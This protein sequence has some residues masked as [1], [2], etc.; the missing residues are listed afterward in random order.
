MTSL[1]MLQR[2]RTP[3]RFRL[4]DHRLN[5]LS[6]PVTWTVDFDRETDLILDVLAMSWRYP[7]PRFRREGTYERRAATKS[8][9]AFWPAGPELLG[10]RQRSRT[11]RRHLL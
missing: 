6:A 11:E 1:T 5:R 2:H 10:V 4:W 8:G 9:A 3:F 7:S